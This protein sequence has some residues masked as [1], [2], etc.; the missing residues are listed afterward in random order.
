MNAYL[1]LGAAIILG[2]LGQ[3][4]LKAGALSSAGGNDLYLN[5]YVAFGLMVYF[6]SALLYIY[7]LK[8]IPVS[9]AF[10]SV[11]V[12]YVLVGLLAYLIWREPFG[13]NQLVGL[14]LIT[15]GLL[16]FART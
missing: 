13:V 5:W 8:T 10:T 12:S 4:S 2:V 11:S 16:I 7:S 15:S 6:M 9:L 3:I 1:S 14:G